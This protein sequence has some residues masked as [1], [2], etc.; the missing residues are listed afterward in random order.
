MS[1]AVELYPGIVSDPNILAGKPVIKGTRV[2]VEL[3]L[4]KLAGGMSMDEV[5]YEYYL[6]VDGVRAALGY[7]AQRIG[8]EV[9]IRQRL[10]EDG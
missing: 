6:S 4:A 9:I 3:V 10:R 1:E 8:E 7:A 5:L 2:T